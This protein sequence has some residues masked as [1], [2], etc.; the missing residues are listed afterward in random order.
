M[1]EKTVL[2]CDR[3]NAEGAERV[4]VQFRDTVYELDL[5]ERHQ[6]PV[7]DCIRYGRQ[8]PLPIPD[9]GPYERVTWDRL[10]QEAR[11]AKK[12]PA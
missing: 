2:L 5:C 11:D 9:T 1:A 7:Q 12:P 4:R 6:R 8:S 10:Q 3:C